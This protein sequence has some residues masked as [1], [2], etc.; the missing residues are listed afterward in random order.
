M[1]KVSFVVRAPCGH[2]PERDPASRQ[3]ADLTVTTVVYRQSLAGVADA[4]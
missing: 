4:I 2:T 3:A 1:L